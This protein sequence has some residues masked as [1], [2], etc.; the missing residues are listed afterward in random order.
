MRTY[1]RKTKRPVLLEGVLELCRLCLNKV[2]IPTPI[3]NDDDQSYCLPL[4][5]RILTCLGFEITKDECLPNIICPQCLEDLNKFYNFKKKC[6]LSYKKLK[7]H[8]LAVKQKENPKIEY[9]ELLGSCNLESDIISSGEVQNGFDENEIVLSLAEEDSLEVINIFNTEEQLTE[10]VEKDEE[11]QIDTTQNDNDSLNF[12]N[13]TPAPSIPFVPEDVSNFLSTILLQLGVL[14]KDNDQIAVVNQTFK[15]VQL[16][17]NDGAVTLELVEEDEDPQLKQTHLKQELKVDNIKNTSVNYVYDA[18]KGL[19]PMGKEICSTCGKRY[20]TRAALV[21]H[22]YIHSGVRPFICEVCNRAFNQRDILRRHMLVHEQ[23]RPFQCRACARG[24]TQR[25]ALRSHELTHMPGRLMALHRC[26]LCPKMFL[27]ASG[28]SRHQATH[29]NRTYACD[30]CSRPFN[31]SSSR[32][33][34]MKICKK[35]PRS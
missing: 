27:H 13:S 22:Q 17:T 28:L 20:S 26:Q 24:F 21:R 6:I 33:R 19:V 18:N 23:E 14:T 29:A 34:H 3:Y 35:R 16:D 9:E 30:S 11:V 8:Y 1:S 10:E 5:M 4:P 12:L 2:T 31:D 7:S 25:A 32:N 15:N